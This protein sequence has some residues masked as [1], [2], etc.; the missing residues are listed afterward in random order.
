MTPSFDEALVEN[1]RMIDPEKI[2]FQAKTSVCLVS[3]C[4]CFSF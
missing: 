3:T 1:H 4:I 2:F